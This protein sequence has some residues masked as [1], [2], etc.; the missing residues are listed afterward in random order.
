MTEETFEFN[1]KNYHL[2]NGRILVKM[3]EFKEKTEGGIYIP[4]T[5]QSK[6]MMSV[7]RGELV[8]YNEFAFKE[9]CVSNDGSIAYIEWTEK[10]KIGDIVFF[11]SYAGRWFYDEEGN[12]YRNMPASELVGFEENE[13]KKKFDEKIENLV[14]TKFG[15]ELSYVLPE[16]KKLDEYF[17]KAKKYLVEKQFNPLKEMEDEENEELYENFLK[18][19][20]ENEENREK[21]FNQAM[22]ETFKEDDELLKNLAKK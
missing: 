11:T 8:K 19:L 18:F 9:R 22:E 1:L 13:E 12:K 16:Q 21:Q 6:M 20:E 15:R 5:S 17:R 3:P 7:I 2:L 10:P 4:E 14:C